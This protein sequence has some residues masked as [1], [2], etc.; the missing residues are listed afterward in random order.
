MGASRC[1]DQ[2]R[3]RDARGPLVPHRPSPTV[4]RAL[5][6]DPSR[7]IQQATLSESST[8]GSRDCK[9]RGAAQLVRGHEA[10]RW[11]TRGRA[12]G[13]RAVSL[14]SRRRAAGPGDLRI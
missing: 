3:E 1:V 5:P 4:L 12:L 13:H 10:V 8:R 6:L 14:S 7:V 2:H 11:T 9:A